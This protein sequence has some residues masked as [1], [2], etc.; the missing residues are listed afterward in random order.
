MKAKCILLLLTILWQIQLLVSQAPQQKEEVCDTTNMKT[1]LVVG[2]TGATGKHVVQQLLDKGHSIRA[3]V[4]SE[5]RMKA[6]LAADANQYGDRLSLT[7]ASL[8]DLS[9]DQLKNL[10]QGTNA[11]VSCLGHTLT[12]KGIWGRPHKLVTD[13]TKKLTEAMKQASPTSKF[14]LMG[15]NG[16]ANPNGLDDPR[17]WTERAIIRIIRYMVPPHADNE[18]AAAYVYN[19]GTNGL[20]WIVV[21][22]S[23]LIDADVSE[24]KLEAKPK[25]LFSTGPATRANVAHCMVDMILNDKVWEEWKFKMP[26][27]HDKTTSATSEI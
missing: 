10:V 21:R 12:F 3:I 13:A 17:P 24:Y 19:L 20:E 11:V 7:E 27:L 8:L 2:A 6:L 14:I 25:G 16:V 15:S 9:D 22:P 5:T 18:D 26:V 23:E 1:V 4:R